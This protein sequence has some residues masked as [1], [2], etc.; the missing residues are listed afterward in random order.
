MF[1]Q[2]TTPQIIIIPLVYD[3]LLAIT[4][5]IHDPFG[6]DLLD[7]PIS[8]YPGDCFEPEATNAVILKPML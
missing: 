3:G 1:Q 8:A 5:M 6:E 2:R 4:Y 7:F